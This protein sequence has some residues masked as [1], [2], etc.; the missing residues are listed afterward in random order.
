[1]AT[2]IVLHAWYKYF[3]GGEFDESKLQC[4]NF[5]YQYILLEGICYL[6]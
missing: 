3:Y 5:P 1:M 2:N 6:A 4:Q